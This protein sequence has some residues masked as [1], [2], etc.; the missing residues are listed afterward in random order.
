MSLDSVLVNAGLTGRG[1][2]RAQGGRRQENSDP[3]APVTEA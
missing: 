2:Y 3:P 1:I